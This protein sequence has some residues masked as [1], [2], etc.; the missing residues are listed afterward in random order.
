LQLGATHLQLKDQ[1][2]S[3]MRLS[4]T[5]G[6]GGLAFAKYTDERY[7]RFQLFYTEG[8]LQSQIS[9]TF[10]EHSNSS[11]LYAGQFNHHEL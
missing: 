4:A 9:N 2:L 10:G 6:T 3:P 11:F 7:R 1:Q 5:R 8:W